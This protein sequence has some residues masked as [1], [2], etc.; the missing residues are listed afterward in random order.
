MAS[1]ATRNNNRIRSERKFARGKC[2]VNYCRD[3]AIGEDKWFCA[4]HT[5]AQ[6]RIKMPEQVEWYTLS[7]WDCSYMAEH[8]MPPARRDMLVKSGLLR[9]NRCFKLGTVTLE[10]ADFGS[11]PGA[12]WIDSHKWNKHYSIPHSRGKVPA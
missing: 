8:K 7:C 12:A 1:T 10:P 6:P 3:A 9:C 5:R 11:I 4:H 2:Q